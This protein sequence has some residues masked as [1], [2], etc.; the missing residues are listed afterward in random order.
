MAIIGEGLEGKYQD[1]YMFGKLCSS[2]FHTL[3]GFYNTSIFNYI[4]KT[5]ST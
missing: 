5:F 2:A 3:W 1:P 4:S